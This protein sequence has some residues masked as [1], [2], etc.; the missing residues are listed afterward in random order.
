MK[1]LKYSQGWSDQIF[2]P[3]KLTNQEVVSIILAGVAGV[4]VGLLIVS[5]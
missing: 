5:L 4:L 1:H 3:R 2:S